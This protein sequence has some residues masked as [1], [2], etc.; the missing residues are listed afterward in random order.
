MR[1]VPVPSTQ[2]DEWLPRIA[3][4]LE[5]F[6]DDGALA[7]SDLVEQIRDRTRQLWIAVDSRVRAVALTQV[8]EDRLSTVRITHVAGDGFEEWAHLREVIKAWAREMGSR[9]LEAIARPGWERV[10][11][12][13]RKTHVVL[14]ERL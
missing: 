4:H 2:L 12:E 3:W 10:A 14:E 11:K 1:A 9:R 6:C 5:R 7:P 13:M 8:S